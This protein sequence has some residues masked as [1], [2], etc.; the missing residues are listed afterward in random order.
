MP[1]NKRLFEKSQLKKIAP[2]W[3]ESHL[4][5]A[6][7]Y[8]KENAHVYKEF[9]KIVNNAL[10]VSPRM[11]ISTDQVLHVIRWNSA[12]A[13]DGDTFAVNDHCGSLFTRL[14]I[15]EYPHR[16][17]HFYTRRSWL[18]RL[19]EAEREQLMLAFEPIRTRPAVWLTK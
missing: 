4:A 5:W 19:T 12:V 11:K 2:D 1:M 13:A 15:E 16:E 8:L 7:W 3:D 9:R 17:R 10:A 6:I 18:D 14:Y